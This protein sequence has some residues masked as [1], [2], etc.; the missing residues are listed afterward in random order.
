VGRRRRGA[1]RDGG[2]QPAPGVQAGPVTRLSRRGLQNV[3]NCNGGQTTARACPPL[4]KRDALGAD[5]LDQS[6]HLFWVWAGDVRRL[7]RF[8]RRGIKPRKRTPRRT[9]TAAA[10]YA[11]VRP[12]HSR[13]GR[14]GPSWVRALTD[15]TAAAPGPVSGSGRKLVSGSERR[16]VAIDGESP[17]STEAHTAQDLW[18]RAAPYE[19]CR[20][21]YWVCRSAAG[22]PLDRTRTRPRIRVGLS[23]RRTLG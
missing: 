17:N 15:E 2:P 21:R 18:R 16:T 22:G 1:R 20:V 19:L 13:P 14:F 12:A 5:G 9:R 7:R 4:H 6:K 3:G 8:R 11:R 23:L 10:P